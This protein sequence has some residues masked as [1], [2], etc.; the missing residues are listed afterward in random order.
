MYFRV[1]L[2]RE[3]HRCAHTSHVCQAF[4]RDV[5]VE[6]VLV[7]DAIPLEIHR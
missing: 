2:Y 5:F 6:F 3:T 7:F 4:C 1:P